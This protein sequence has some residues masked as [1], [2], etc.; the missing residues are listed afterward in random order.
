MYPPEGRK[1][2]ETKLQ[3]R[4]IQ[5]FGEGA[6]PFSLTFPELAP[7]SVLICADENEDPAQV[8]ELSDPDTYYPLP[9]LIYLLI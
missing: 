5:K 3:S 1:E 7:N 2:D 9:L 4:L 8:D 6:F